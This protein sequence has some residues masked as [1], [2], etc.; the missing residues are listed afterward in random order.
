MM[1]SQLR[2]AC[3]VLRREFLQVGIIDV[4]HESMTI[5]SACNK[6][7]RKLFLK[8][9][10]IGLIP[11]GGYSG[12]VNYSKNAMMWLVYTEHLDCCRIMHGR[13]CHEI[14]L[15][16][17]PRLSVNDFC[18]ET[19]TV[20][21]FCGY[22]WHGNKCLPY[23]DVTTGAGD[24]IDERYERTMARIEQITHSGYQVDKEILADHTDLMYPVVQHSPLNTRDALFGDRKEAMRL[25]HTAGDGETIQ[26]DNVMSLY[27]YK[28]KYF[29]FPIG[30]PMI[31]VG[32]A[33][34]DMQTMLLKDGLMKFSILPLR[35][36]FHPV[37]PFRC[38]K[39][40][41]FCPCRSC[42][43][44]QNRTEDCTHETFAERALTETWVLD[45]IR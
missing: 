21:E 22:Y 3:R 1:T 7:L 25:H 20:Y 16:A 14:N 38:N 45:E 10:T 36:L 24:T 2:Q 43:M 32:D 37:L 40:L 12:N 33:C 41:L 39:R 35:C 44:E 42:A 26:Y 9:D 6:V 31:H 13:N 15:P 29:K 27:P 5:A 19:N 34:Q 11:I 18:R 8:P 4:F 23:R 30:H 17:L 28:F